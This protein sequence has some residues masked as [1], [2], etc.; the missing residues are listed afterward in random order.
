MK[1]YELTIS[2]ASALLSQ[3]QLTSRELTGSVLERIHAVEDRVGAYITIN[4]ELA[5]AQAEIADKAISEGRGAALTGIPLAIKDLICT[6]GIRT[7]CASR[8]LENFIPPYDATVI[9]KL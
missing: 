9:Q 4:D 8:I 7:T 6:Q 2:Q 1:L 3:G 5:M